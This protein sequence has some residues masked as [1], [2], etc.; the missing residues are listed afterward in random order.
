MAA[1]SFSAAPALSHQGNRGWQEIVTKIL[2]GKDKSS[3]HKQIS[4]AANYRTIYK[5]HGSPQNWRLEPLKWDQAV[6][7]IALG[8]SLEFRIVPKVQK[9]GM[10][11][12]MMA[13]YGNTAGPDCG[14]T[15]KEDENM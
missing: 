11:A 15:D 14:Y 3:L 13:A 2:E 10:A 8:A 12:M 7:M 1:L 9:P 6:T 5:L 4:E